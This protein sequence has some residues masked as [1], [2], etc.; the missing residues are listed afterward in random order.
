MI[1]GCHPEDR[2]CSFCHRSVNEV[3][4]TWYEGLPYHEKCFK[5]SLANELRIFDKKKQLG[6]LTLAEAK[7]MTDIQDMY[8]VERRS[9]ASVQLSKMIFTEIPVFNGN[10]KLSMTH[11]AKKQI[12]SPSENVRISTNEE[13][14]ISD[15][16]GEK[17]RHP[18]P[19]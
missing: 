7:R 11:M 17:F 12:M 2:P 18:L 15:G 19:A 1:K 4:A 13:R 10:T 6:T 8:D 5:L 3:D 14:L 16:K 9:P